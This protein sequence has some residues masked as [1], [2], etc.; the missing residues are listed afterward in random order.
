MNDVQFFTN[1]NTQMSC[2]A[3]KII[4]IIITILLRCLEKYPKYIKQGFSRFLHMLLNMRKEQKLKFP[5]YT[6]LN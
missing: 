2:I 3:K 5:K 1:I 6:E 4:I